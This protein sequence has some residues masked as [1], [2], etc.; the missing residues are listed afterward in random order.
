V[1]ASLEEGRIVIEHVRPEV[2]HGR[3]RAKA[4]VGD[5]VEVR[6]DVFRDGFEVLRAVVL[7]RGPGQDQWS[8]ASMTPLE[9][10]RWSGFFEPLENGR[11]AYTI[12]AW[13][14]RFATWQRDLRKK[15]DAG[16]SVEPEFEEGALILESR[17]ESVPPKARPSVQ[18]IIDG[19]RTRP[20]EEGGQDP[21]LAAGLDESV[22]ATIEACSDPTRSVT[23]SPVLEL[24]VDRER[25]HFGSWYELFPRSTGTK[26]RHG[27][28]QTA[29]ERLPAIARMGFDIVYLPP[30]HPIG[31]TDR[32]GKNNALEAGPG[33][34]GSPWA[35]GSEQGGHT[36]I[37]PELGTINDFDDFVA[38]AAREGLEV[39]LDYA[40]Q[41]SPDHPWVTE[42]P[43]WFRHRADGTIRFAE[44][45]PKK[46]QDIYPVNFDTEERDAL[47]NALKDIIEFW[48]SHGVKAFRV[49]NPHTKP[50][51]FW[52]W[53]IDSIQTDYPDVIFLAE[54][55][56]RSVSMQRA[57]AK[58]GF[59]QNYTYFTW[60]NTKTEILELMTELTEDCVPDYYRPNFFTNTPDILHEYLQKG[61]PPAF[62]VR[63]VLAALLSPAYGIYSG[64]ELFENTPLRE[65][66]EEYLDSE[67]FE[68]K[69]RDFSTSHS[70]I[71]YISRINEI[72]QSFPVLSHFTNF[73]FHEA[74][75]DNLLAFSKNSSGD[76]PILAIVNLNPKKTEE[77][78]VELDLDVLGAH[79]STSLKL[80]D[81]ISDESQVW[82][83]ST[84]SVFLDPADEPALIFRVDK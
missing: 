28:F 66:S 58:A 61:G 48:I 77:G 23:Y 33:D 5:R 81:L 30:I 37:H 53:L 59:T 15:L 43:E 54:A 70:L 4:I 39:A 24:S 63:L 19:L 36:A 69:P 3:Y 47:W 45:P 31:T 80:H 64:F 60:A 18:R 17:L 50:V 35:I 71:P 14:D 26:T 79:D 11:Y 68:L 44:N 62:K 76:D 52:E 20:V 1:R 84:G 67:K 38:A 21:R 55:F 10:D 41:C 7:Y 8:Q 13:T 49:D 75:N 25:A 78:T 34:I 65:G 32:K 9:A 27:T 6:A 73:H 51:A 46:Y 82:N 56:T 57:L 29:A 42:H 16:Q 2:D 83:G 12:R 72:R 74:D 40:I 22:T